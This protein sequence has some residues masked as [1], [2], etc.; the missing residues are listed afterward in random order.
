MKFRAGGN[1]KLAV[2]VVLIRATRKLINS[3]TTNHTD[4]FDSRSS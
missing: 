3:R 2:D 4:K 1:W